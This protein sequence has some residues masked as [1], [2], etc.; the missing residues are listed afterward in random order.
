MEYRPN[1]RPSIIGALSM[2]AFGVEIASFISLSARS[3][4]PKTPSKQRRSDV[5]PHE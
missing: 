1:R 5:P 4:S 2:C 3:E